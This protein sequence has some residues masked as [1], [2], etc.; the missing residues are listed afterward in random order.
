M[1]YFKGL[2]KAA[3]DKHGAV[4]RD[5]TEQGQVVRRVL[6]DD[7]GEV[8][9]GAE[10]RYIAELQPLLLPDVHKEVAQGQA[11]RQ[12]DNKG[13]PGVSS[14]FGLCLPQHVL[15]RHQGG[16]GQAHNR[17]Q[18]GPQ[19]QRL[20]VLQ[21]GQGQV[22]LRQQ[23]LL[24]SRPSGWHQARRGPS[25]KAAEER[26]QRHRSFSRELLFFLWTIQYFWPLK[27]KNF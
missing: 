17:L 13:V 11:V 7:N 9:E 5:P 22:S 4:V 20:Q 8:L 23:V 15:G 21:Q 26:R 24:P 12:Q 2:C 25:H 18:G 27:K 19:H 3:R 1:F 10:V 16:E 14:P 6:R